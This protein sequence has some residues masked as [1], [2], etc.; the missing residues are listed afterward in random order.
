MRVGREYWTKAAFLIRGSGMTE[1]H[2]TVNAD[3]AVFAEAALMV[4][5]RSSI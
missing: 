3:Y 2:D 5:M 1:P 4:A